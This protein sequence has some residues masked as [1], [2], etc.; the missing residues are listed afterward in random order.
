MFPEE[1][2]ERDRDV[3]AQA[4]ELLREKLPQGWAM[5]LDPEVASSG[6]ALVDALIQLRGPSGSVWLAVE[7]KRVV[8]P[9]DVPDIVERLRRSGERIGRTPVLPTIVGRYLS[10]SARSKIEGGDA[11]YLDATGNARIVADDPLVLLQL[12]GADRDPWRGPGRPR[13]SLK[14][15]PAARVVRA[16]VDYLPPLSVPELIERSGAS[17]GATYRVVKYLE[18]QDLIRREADGSGAVVAVRWRQLLESWSA[19]YGF[20]RADVIRRFIEP[21]G[22]D[23][24]IDRLR[25]ADPHSYVV[26][27]SAAAQA[28]A[29]YAP[30]RLLT[31][32]MRDL[33][34]AETSLGLRPIDKGANVLVAANKDDFAFDRSRRWEGLTLA[35]RSQVFV[36][37]MSGPGRSPSEAQELL[38]WM[39]RNEDVWRST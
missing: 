24:V 12:S 19:D 22:V 10:P 4:A 32:Y 21:R 13:G 11:C 36:D 39:E 28:D 14:G 17:T 6:G 35:A 37:L 5:E 16:L 31:I 27:G 1:P 34:L 29:P 7:V 33:G 3:L 30:L 38:G 9:R 25:Q 15:A 20:H 2:P 8:V 18:E 23:A 26:T